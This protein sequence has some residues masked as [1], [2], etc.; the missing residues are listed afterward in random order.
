MSKQEIFK[1]TIPVL[2]GYIPLGLAFGIYGVASGMPL[3]VLALTC[4]FIYAGSV[5]FV[6]VAFIVAKASL[7]EVFIISF[8]LNFRH[9][10]YTMTLLDD[11]KKLKNR[12][13]FIYALTDETFALLVSRPKN[14]NENTNLLFNLTAFF[15]HSY[16]ITGVLLGAFLGHNLPVRYDGVEFS[17]VALFAILTYEL[18]KTNPNYKVLF[19]AFS[20]AFV[21]LFI[22]PEQYFLF[23]SLIMATAI[24]LIIR[25]YI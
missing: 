21:G 22:F 3:W 6:L 1:N 11:I 16:W 18:F 7:L 25:K 17:L 14:K 13:Y 20:C 10:F 9:F 23:G 4:I 2:L 24:L 15:N 5:E 19:L 8:L 12:L